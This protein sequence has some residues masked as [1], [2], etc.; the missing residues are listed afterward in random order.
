MAWDITKDLHK[1]MMGCDKINGFARNVLITGNADQQHA[2]GRTTQAIDP[3]EDNVHV[4]IQA[5][6]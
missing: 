3:T 4:D 5:P 1:K 2:K 6:G